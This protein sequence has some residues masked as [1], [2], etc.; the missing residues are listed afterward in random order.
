[1][2]LSFSIILILIISIII[3]ILLGD[4]RNKYHPV[5]WIG[6]IINY[7]IPKLKINKQGSEACEKIRGIKFTILFILSSVILLHSFLNILTPNYYFIFLI[8]SVYLLYSSISIKSMENHI[9]MIIDALNK[10]DILAARKKL[11]MIVGRNTKELDEEHIIS[12]A[13]ESIAD[14]TVDGIISPLFYFSIFGACGAFIFRIINT[15]DAMIGYRD[16]YFINIGWMAAKIDTFANYIPSRIT[17]IIIIIS[18][19][20]MKADWK[21]SIKMLKRD[22][23]N[24]ISVN[25]GYPI[26]AMAGALNVR[27]EKIDYYQIGIPVE[28]LSIEKCLVAIKIMKITVVLFCL[29]ISIPIILLLGL[30]KWWNVL[31]GI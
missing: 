20:L 14:S 2:I 5:A 1:M 30:I 12:G 25:S 26:S 31:F 4:P 24:T 17:S 28:K 3:D 13:I 15:L 18:S 27:L 6:K 21:N 7:F 23:H 19:F 22:R 11:S 10:Q 16:H 8:L 9:N 29:C